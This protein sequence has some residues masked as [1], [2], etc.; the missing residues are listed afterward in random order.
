MNYAPWLRKQS[1]K[2]LIGQIERR[3]VSHLIRSLVK[4]PTE[5]IHIFISGIIE[6]MAEYSSSGQLPHSCVSL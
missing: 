1:T 3:N 5:D 6:H 2:L 4:W